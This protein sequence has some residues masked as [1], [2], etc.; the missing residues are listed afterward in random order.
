MYISR[1]HVFHRILSNY[2]EA[3]HHTIVF[4]VQHVAM[5]HIGYHIIGEIDECFNDLR[6]LHGWDEHHILISCI[7]GIGCCAVDIVDDELSFMNMEGV[8][9]MC[10]I[11][12]PPFLNGVDRH[13]FID[14]I[15]IKGCTVD[16]EGAH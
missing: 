16:H 1:L 15:H 11:G 13:H 5:V 9:D 12:D 3:A 4:V 6:V 2:R 14:H 8:R 10:V 7:H